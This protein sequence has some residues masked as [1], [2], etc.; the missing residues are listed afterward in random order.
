[1]KKIEIIKKVIP[2]TFIALS[3]ILSSISTSVFSASADGESYT[4]TR[5][6]YTDKYDSNKKEILFYSDYYFKHSSTIY[7]EHLATLSM[8]SAKYSMNVGG[9]DSV[10]STQWYE[11]QP[12]RLESYLE[13][14]EF[15]KFSANEDYH[16]RTGLWTIGVGV[17][18]KVIE[19]F[20][21]L[22]VTTRS[23][24]YFNEWSNNVMLGKGDQSDYMHEGW[25]YCANKTIDYIATYIKEQKVSGKIKLWFSGFSRGGAVVNI[26]GGLI[27]NYIDQGTVNKYF[28]GITLT[29][30]DLFVYTFESPQGANVNSTTVKSP[31]DQIYN[32]IFNIVNPN[33]LVPKVAMHGWGF[34]RFGIDKYVI[35]EFFDPTNFKASRDTFKAFYKD[36]FSGDD[37]TVYKGASITDWI[38]F[39]NGNFS[40]FGTIAERVTEQIMDKSTKLN[41]DANIV[42]NLVFE[43]GVEA[44]GSREDYA[45]KYQDTAVRAL[46]SFVTDD[47]FVGS[48]PNILEFINEL[49][50]L[51]LGNFFV[52]G[53]IFNMAEYATFTAS[54]ELLALAKVLVEVIGKR[55]EDTFSFIKNVA[56]IFDNHGTFVSVAF[57]KAQDSFYID[58][59]N[60]DSDTK[61]KIAPLRKDASY[62][63]LFHWSFNDIEVY[64]IKADGSPYKVAYIEGSRFHKSNVKSCDKG[65]AIGY[66][67]YGIVDEDIEVFIPA[68]QGYDVYSTFYSLVPVKKIRMH[69]YLYNTN[70]LYEKT[71]TDTFI[72]WAN[73]GYGPLVKWYPPIK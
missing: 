33:D 21:V 60:S 40:I 44:I 30:D 67:H 29:H 47:K 61:I 55:T 32:N 42:V 56:N 1:M 45:E 39:Y 66:Y 43:A 13:A 58:D 18:Q 11:D 62:R 26:A 59:Y 63:R 19:D 2:I 51:A 35:T 50:F 48:E 16:S 3:F 57:L 25:H 9:P 23:G 15:E 27:D 17:A 46:W 72:K 54:T 69:A 20:T 28:E 73:F 53:D 14:I 37:F 8:M 6:E 65:H 41:Y 31:K 22:S 4:P 36:G 7:D 5:I 52:G 49:I 68:N 10:D 71:E 34:T 70:N 24:G 12:K 64:R 38:P